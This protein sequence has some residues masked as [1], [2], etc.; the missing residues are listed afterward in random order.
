MDY[1]SIKALSKTNKKFNEYIQDNSEY[2][3]KKLL[4][5]D[6]K[7]ITGYKELYELLETSEAKQT[8]AYKDKC[9]NEG[10][11]ECKTLIKDTNK[12]LNSGNSNIKRFMNVYD[13]IIICMYNYKNT[14][15]VNKLLKSNFLQTIANKLN[16]I[17]EKVK[18]KPKRKY[19]IIWEKWFPI[20]ME[21]IL[22]L[23]TPKFN[24]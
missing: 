15:D 16:D 11:F 12:Y 19:E 21:K 20:T 6:Y 17:N 23:Y 8:K 7:C 5:R 13:S 24:K 1:K 4:E 22:T 3:Y 18:L 9:V 2:L 14:K 10:I